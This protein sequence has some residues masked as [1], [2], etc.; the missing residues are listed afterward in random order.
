MSLALLAAWAGP[1]P[2]WAQTAGP[3]PAPTTPTPTDTPAALTTDEQIAGAIAQLGD[4]D[5]A[6]RERAT[7]A[8]WAAGAAAEPALRLALNAAEPEVAGRI[9]TILANVA[10][11]ITPDMSPEVIDL[12]ARYRAGHAGAK[13]QVA[14][15]LAQRGPGGARVL[16]RLRDEERDPAARAG[17]SLILMRRARELAVSL[18][19]D[20]DAATA[21]RV[22]AAAAE[23]GGQP[24]AISHAAHRNYAAFLLVH[25]GLDEQIAATAARLDQPPAA[26]AAPPGPAPA[27][28]HPRLRHVARTPAQDAELLTFLHRA[29]GNLPA[30]RAAA[31]RSGD[32]ELLHNILIEIGDWKALAARAA[33][34]GERADVA[35]LSFATAFHRLAGDVAGADRFAALLRATAD[36]EP[37]NSEDVAEGLFLNGRTDLGLDV[38]A[39]HGHLAS[40]ARFHT[41][42]LAFDQVPRLLERA[43]ARDGA[44]LRRVEAEGARALWYTGQAEAAAAQLAAL[45][46]T[47]EKRR[48]FDGFAAV[49]DA[50]HE[51]GLAEP[52]R[53]YVVAALQVAAADPGAVAATDQRDPLADM[54]AN[55]RARDAAASAAWWRLLRQRFPKQPPAHTL[56]TIRAIDGRRM[57]GEELRALCDASAEHATGRAPEERQAQLTLVADT[58]AAAGRLEDAT[59][60]YHELVSLADATNPAWAAAPLG[61]LAGLDADAG[62]WKAAARRYLE[63]W[64]RD[65]SRPA[66]L[67][68]SGWALSQAGGGND[69]STGKQRMERAHLISLADQDL[70]YSLYEALAAR[71]L[72]DP[73][74]RERDLILRTSEFMSWRRSEALRRAGDE[75]YGSARAT[76]AADFWE[77]AF[78][79]NN[80][81]RTRFVD[82][83]ANV[84]I[85]AM[86]RRTRAVGRVQDGDVPGAPEEAAACLAIS[87]GDVDSLIEI[88]AAL[89]AAGH[90]AEGDALYRRAAARYEELSRRY[91]Q[92]GP[93]H[94]LCAWAAAKC[95]R[96]LDAALA[97]AKRAVELRPANTDWLDTL[98]ETHFQRGEVQ[99]AIVAMQRCAELEPD[100]PRHKEQLDRFQKAAAGAGKS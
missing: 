53:W 8:L 97:H 37:H 18:I 20:G 52:A 45:A 93:L 77:R 10:A 31:E 26:N 22:L 5:F 40:A 57:K 4:A 1:P 75:A 88:V 83:W 13:R 86:V 25:G 58:L 47:C 23:A 35:G 41:R 56:E 29:K 54:F 62:R 17:V 92:S 44:D 73:A 84:S 60:Y 89:D 39:R 55:A 48:D 50:A 38:L 100:E 87:P 91:P 81:K 61:K 15:M 16:L 74:R 28:H 12:V 33:A 24:T 34:A 6:V 90:A 65:R 46:K 96:D 19:G 9:R 27:A 72:G 78:L 63:A 49:I 95:K 76:A 14:D 30:A 66:P 98:A 2:C 3:P 51:M 82:A 94:N 42:R 71:K 68:L 21:G 79:D 7:R 99:L 67:Y 11:G 80:D 69:A 64:G 85:P 59:R 32:E 43:R 36:R 70:R